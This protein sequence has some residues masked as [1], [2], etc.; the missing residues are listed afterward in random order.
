MY[1]AVYTA[2]IDCVRVFALLF[3]PNHPRLDSRVS[4]L[5]PFL[6]VIPPFCEHLSSSKNKAGYTAALV[7]CSRAGAV[8]EKV[9][10]VF[11]QEQ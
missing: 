9:T 6:P 8:M 5:V 4:G 11:G 3:L 10:G 1:T 7:A 2:L